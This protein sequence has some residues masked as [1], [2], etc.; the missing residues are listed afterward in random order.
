MELDI[1]VIFNNI[2]L[3]LAR[4]LHRNKIFE[5]IAEKEKR[6]EMLEWRAAI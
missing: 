1:L 4:E 5:P 2:K 6:R 3:F